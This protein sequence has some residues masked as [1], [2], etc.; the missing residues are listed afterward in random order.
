MLNQYEFLRV[1]CED[2]LEHEEDFDYMEFKLLEEIGFYHLDELGVFDFNFNLEADEQY[3]Y[4]LN[5]N[6]VYEFSA[7]TFNVKRNLLMIIMNLFFRI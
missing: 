7:K 2:N 6:Q 3:K 5:E 4:T 1:W